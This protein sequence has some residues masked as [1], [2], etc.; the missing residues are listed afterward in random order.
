MD[1]QQQEY[2][3]EKQRIEQCQQCKR[4]MDDKSISDRL[5]DVFINTA[6]VRHGMDDRPEIIVQQN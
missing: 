6:L 2:A 5:V 3:I 1:G 4:D